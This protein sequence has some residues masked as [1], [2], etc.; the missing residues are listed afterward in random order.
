MHLTEHVFADYMSSYESIE[1]TS[2]P[3][4]TTIN[5]QKQTLLQTLQQILPH[6]F[7]SDMPAQN[8]ADTSE[9]A[10]DESEVSSAATNTASALHVPTAQDKYSNLLKRFT[11]LVAGIQPS[12]QTPLAELHTLLHAPDMFL[13]ITVVAHE[14]KL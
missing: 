10:A 13:Y 2:Q 8:T 6:C 11:V 14:G 4:G 3:V 7:R 9:A 5:G 12:L 1:Y